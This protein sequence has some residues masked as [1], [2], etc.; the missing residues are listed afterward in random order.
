[1]SKARVLI[2]ALWTVALCSLPACDA[3]VDPLDERHNGESFYLYGYLDSGADTQFVRVQPIRATAGGQPGATLDVDVAT[4][5]AG[6]G[7]RVPWRDSLIVL[8]D[9]TVG[10][11]FFAPFRPQ[12]GG[13]YRLEIRS[14]TG[15][16]TRT[17]TTVPA[18]APEAQFFTMTSP[19][20]PLIERIVWTGWPAPPDEV[21]VVYTVSPTLSELPVPIAIAYEP[22]RRLDG[23]V[24]EAGIDLA[25]DARKIR[26]RLGVP[27]NYR[28]AALYRV[29]IRLS[30]YSPD[31]RDPGRASAVENGAGFFGSVGRF[32]RSV[33]LEPATLDR[34]G[35]INRQEL[36]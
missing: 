17:E 34:L 1:M 28:L 22:L 6:S 30:L 5:E 20:G 4:T 3:T 11:L 14:R 18:L 33:L 7:A 24:W 19:L 15:S 13:A 27:D 2:T 25:A 8:D 9:G 26:A 36:P 35:F 32:T 21:E 29:Q 12:P 16:L 31:W 23:T 10:H